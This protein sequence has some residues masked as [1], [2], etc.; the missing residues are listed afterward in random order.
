MYERTYWQDHVTEFDN[1]FREQNNA[2]GTIS[3]IPVE[4]EII[5]Q[6]TPQNAANFNRIETG[7]FAATEIMAELARITLHSGS[8]T[9][10]GGVSDIPEPSD[11]NIAVMY[12]E[13]VLSEVEWKETADSVF[14]D[15]PTAGVTGDMIPVV[16]ITNADR[17][18]S[19]I[20]GLDSVAETFDGVIRFF[21][22]SP[23]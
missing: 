4:G 21:A 19:T 13:I 7:I 15:V 22:K 8:G 10:N 12:R 16:A 2:D 23:P 14:I 6:G 18:T 11:G 17:L 5:Q 1:R 9:V 20:C 3:H